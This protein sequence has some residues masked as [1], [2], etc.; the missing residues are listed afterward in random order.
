MRV[1]IP[2]VLSAL[3]L[4]GGLCIVGVVVPKVPV[5]TAGTGFPV[6]RERTVLDSPH[7]FA[8][9]LTVVAAIALV[10]WCA[11]GGAGL[12]AGSAQDGRR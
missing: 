4:G 5:S 1:A 8:A 10:D 7:V 12:S 9:A 3:R 11:L 6:S 2:V